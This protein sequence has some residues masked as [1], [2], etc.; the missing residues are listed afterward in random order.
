[1]NLITLFLTCA[2]EQEA[3]EISSKLLDDK[4]AACVRQTRVTSDFIWKG[5][6]EHSNEV[7]LIIESAQEKFDEIEA[8]V[9][10]LH[11]Y[12]TFVLTAYSVAK[13]SAG[14][15]QWV[16]ES[17]NAE[18]KKMNKLGEAKLF[19]DGG[20][21]GNPGP[22]AIAFVI[23]KMDNS[24]VEKSGEYIG[25]TTNNQAEYQ[26]LKMGL[27]RAHELGVE[28][29]IVSLDSELVVKQ[30][31]GLYKIKNAELLPH[32]NEVKQLAGQF[33]QITFQ[34]VPRALNAEADKELNRILDAEQQ[35]K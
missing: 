8:A 2:D 27:K 12:E 17:I 29:L 1:M 22:S 32:Y 13:A 4:L 21:R 11:S 19:T 25:S 30:I 7:L 15:E 28:K 24:V 35:I 33:E 10:K 14:V 34:H 3:K 9:K 23:C 26:A 18:D 6:K 5:K 31:N 20:S 16:S